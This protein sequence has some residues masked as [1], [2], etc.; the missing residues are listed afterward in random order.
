MLRLTKDIS[1]RSPLIQGFRSILL[2]SHLCH[3]TQITLPI[4][5]LPQQNTLVSTAV[6]VKRIETV[7]KQSKGV[8]TELSRH[9]AIE[10]VSRE[11]IFFISGVADADAVFA[12]SREK[13]ASTFRA[14]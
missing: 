2:L 3:V 9:S 6:S 10:H 13:I 4:L 8:F 7:L 11:I 12:F 5:L 1:G 14:H